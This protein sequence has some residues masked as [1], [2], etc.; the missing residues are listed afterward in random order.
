MARLAIVL[1]IIAVTLRDRLTASQPNK[2]DLESSRTV[3]FSSSAIYSA[4]PHAVHL[5]INE[6]DTMLEKTSTN[7]K[8]TNPQ[9][10]VLF[11]SLSN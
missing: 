2:H 11:F 5:F 7:K 3:T 8:K 6:R 10:R 9:V 1:E 4:D